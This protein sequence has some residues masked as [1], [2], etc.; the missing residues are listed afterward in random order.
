[1]PF[2]TSVRRVIDPGTD[3]VSAGVQVLYLIVYVVVI[4][5]E[6]R[7]FD[8]AV[9]KFR[10]DT[11]YGTI[12]CVL[13]IIGWAW[14]SYGYYFT[15]KPYKCNAECELKLAAAISRSKVDCLLELRE[16]MIFGLTSA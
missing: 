12:F 7:T 14:F 11:I 4:I 9:I 15:V 10:Y 6:Q 1:M 13:Y 8:P 5:I 16:S 2:R 3:H